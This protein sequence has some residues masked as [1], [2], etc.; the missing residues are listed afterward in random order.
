MADDVRGRESYLGELERFV[1]RHA[2]EE[3][4]VVRRVT[5]R[6]A[7]RADELVAAVAA[8]LPGVRIERVTAEGDDGSTVGYWMWDV[9]GYDGSDG[10]GPG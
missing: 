1:R 8:G 7:A 3:G 5:K 4:V 6:A 2:G 10:W 9:S